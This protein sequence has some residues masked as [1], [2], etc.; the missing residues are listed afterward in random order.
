MSMFTSQIKPEYLEAIRKFRLID[1]TFFNICFDGDTNSME[2]LLHIFLQRDDIKVLEVVTQRTA[3]NLYGRS[4]RFDVLAID[5]NG[6]I[7]NVEVQRATEGANPKRARFNYCL[8]DSREI[9]KGTEY[10]NFPEVWVIFITE[11][12]IFGAKHPMY[13]IERTITEL[14]QP[15]DDAEHT[16]YVNGEYKGSDALGLLMHDFFCTDPA[17]MHYPQLAKRADFFKHKPKGMKTM[18]EIMEKIQEVGRAEGRAEG[19]L[20]MLTKLVL[21]NLKKNKPLEEIAESLDI[22]TKEVIRIGKENGL[23]ITH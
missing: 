14:N 10:Q 20:M 5:S 4:V 22:T 19:S 6:K 9:N 17:K 11:K 23:T 1:D 15:F 3:Q 8:I 12:D 13:H 16:I 2:L 21:S 18:C 7:Y